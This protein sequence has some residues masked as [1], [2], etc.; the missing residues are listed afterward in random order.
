MALGIGAASTEEHGSPSAARRGHWKLMERLAGG[1]LAVVPERKLTAYLL[2]SEHRRGGSKARFLLR[3]GFRG[4]AWQELEAALRRHAVEGT[5]T[6]QQE[7]I[8][9]VTYVVEGPLRTPDGRDP[10]YRSVWIVEW[11][12]H[13][14]R[15]VTAYPP[16]S[17]GRP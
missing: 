6:G 16:T 2:A 10:P 17:G 4:E 3:F 15:L 5:V 8:H 1:E 13:S 7:G 12:Q 11:G 9:G 14:P